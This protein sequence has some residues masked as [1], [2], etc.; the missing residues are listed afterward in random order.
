MALPLSDGGRTSFARAMLTAG[1]FSLLALQL[2]SDEGPSL[3]KG[4]PLRWLAL[5]GL[6]TVLSCF[7]SIFKDFSVKEALAVWSVI[8]ASLL[9]GHVA[10]QDHRRALLVTVLA[11]GVLVTLLAF[12]PYLA[13]PAGSQA[14][15]ALSGS[16]HY[17][18][19]LGSFLLLIVF[20]PCAFLFHAG[21]RLAS[22]ASACALALLGASLILTHSRG[23]W[24]A[25]VIAL[26]V[27]TVVEWRLIW[28][29][30]RSMALAALLLIG[31]VLIASRRPAEIAPRFASLATATSRESDDPSYRWRWDIYAWTLDII[32]DH[33]WV[34]TGIGTFPI[35]IKLY[36]RAPYVSGLYAHNHYLQTAAEMG[37]PALAGLLLFLGFLVR[38]GWRIIRS[39][40]PRSAE[41]SLALGLAVGLLASA[42]HAAVDLGWSYPAVALLAGVEAA[43]LLGLVHRSVTEAERIVSGRAA[44][45]PVR[46]VLLSLCLI[47]ALLAGTRYYA[48]LLRNIGKSALEVGERERAIGALRW[49][50]RLNPLY[51]S[52]RYLLASA[53]AAE[54][55]WS[56]SE[57]EAE[58]AFRLDRYDGDAYHG[59]ARIR[60]LAGKREQAQSALLA[61]VRLQPYTRLSL[62]HD[63]GELLLGL[64]KPAEALDWL[65]KGTEIF[66][67]EIVT[68]RVPRCLE[69]GDRY[70]LARIYWRMAEIW[71][72]EGSISQGEQADESASQLASPALEEICFRA[73]TGPYLSPESTIGAYWRSRSDADWPGVS[74]TIAN[75]ADQQL[76]EESL[77]VLP[78]QVERVEVAWIVSLVG[79]EDEAKVN[80]EVQLL[81]RDGTMRKAAFRDTLHVERGGWRLRHREPG[82]K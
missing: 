37:L 12:P 21:T 32:K 9:G 59:L 63:L 34:G 10:A 45:R 17:P 20:L 76:K 64:G 44:L 53:Y 75:D 66:R 13:A 78:A 73:M 22:V 67:P 15:S 50:S 11:S 40:E 18:N 81:S 61:A 25:G 41:R 5:A 19:G 70:I 79:N 74:A 27:W 77:S 35:A 14:A 57:R 28:A 38:R 29:H 56:S 55:D 54:R 4:L 65:K 68:S 52:P 69:P 7:T 46:P 82:L 36:Q 72:G 58:A 33:P 47:M 71:R 42:L 23:V 6:L 60:W 51:Y 30:R 49:A 2:I 80:Y 43:I 8:G 1:V 31:I 26:I 62:Y 3:I 16:F 48:E 24:A 39:L